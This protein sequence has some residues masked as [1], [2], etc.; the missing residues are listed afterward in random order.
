MCTVLTTGDEWLIDACWRFAR[1]MYVLG[2]RA[3]DR[4]TS[5]RSVGG[6]YA[7]AR[8]DRA[9]TLAPAARADQR[10]AAVTHRRRPSRPAAGGTGPRSAERGL[11]CWRSRR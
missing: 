2:T 6:T 11:Q 7:G 1:H 9:A 4:P 3:V 10:R 5:E 8:A